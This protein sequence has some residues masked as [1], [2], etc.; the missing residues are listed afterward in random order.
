MALDRKNITDVINGQIL[1]SERYHLFANLIFLGGCA[2]SFRRR[3]KKLSIRVLP[4][5]VDQNPKTPLG[6]AKSSGCF[7]TGDSVDKVCSQGFILSMR[8]VCGLEEEAGPLY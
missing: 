7:L 8:G 6:V 3:H 1:F 2:G 5:L 4:E